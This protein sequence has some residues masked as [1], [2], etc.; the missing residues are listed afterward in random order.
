MGMARDLAET[1]QDEELLA[2][3]GAGDPNAARLL[4]A[5]LAP[6]VFAFAMRMLGERSE[7]E[8]VAQEAMLRLWRAAPGWRSGEAQ[9]STWLYRVVRNLVTDRMRARSRQGGGA[10]ALEDAPDP[11]DEAPGAEAQIMT[12]LRHD[13]LDRALALLPER[14][15]EAVILRHIEGLSNPEIAE[16]MGI[17]VEAVESLTSRGKRGLAAAL[18]GQKA[19]LGFEGE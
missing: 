10:L 16:I 5:R 3:Y 13:A 15:R 19:D 12:G 2:L 14:Q 4:T 9:V 6:R 8:D 1:A 7:A 17:G 11:V 18:V